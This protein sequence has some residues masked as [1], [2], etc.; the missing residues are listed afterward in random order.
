MV[1]KIIALVLAGLMIFPFAACKSSGA[2]TS[3]QVTL[4]WVINQDKQKDTDVVE[5]EI[6]NLFQNC[7][8]LDS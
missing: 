7:I 3:K 5:K 8:L 2:D 1:K 6:N 4:T